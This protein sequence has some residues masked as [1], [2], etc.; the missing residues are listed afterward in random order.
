MTRSLIENGVISGWTSPIKSFEKIDNEKTF[1]PVE[2]E[3][4]FKKRDIYLFYDVYDEILVTRVGLR[5]LSYSSTSVMGLKP[6]FT[7]PSLNCS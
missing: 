3:D 1:A 4:P 6:Y 7:M 5:L 2:I